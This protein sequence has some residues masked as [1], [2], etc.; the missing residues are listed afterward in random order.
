MI[1]PKTLP[2]LLVLAGITTFAGPRVA[3][4]GE[5]EDLK[6]QL[7]ALQSRIEK[8]EDYQKQAATVKAVVP[9]S[10]PAGSPAASNVTVGT[11]QSPLS[12]NVGGGVVTLYGNL[13][14]YLNYMKSSSGGRI[15]SA[16]DGAFLRSRIGF[17]GERA[18]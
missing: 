5:L 6:A 4:A 14:E 18:I 9:A 17:K 2:A 15:F 1:R 11:A 12:L 10:V 7:Q 8:M 13:D 16:Q 3:L